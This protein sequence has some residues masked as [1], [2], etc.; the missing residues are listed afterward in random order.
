M[1]LRFPASGP[2]GEEALP[3]RPRPLAAAGETL[4]RAS[5]AHGAAGQE[6]KGGFSKEK[7]VRNIRARAHAPQML[8][9]REVENEKKANFSQL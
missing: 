6:A 5:E 8:Q 3:A 1:G 9:A 4:R 2:C 7:G